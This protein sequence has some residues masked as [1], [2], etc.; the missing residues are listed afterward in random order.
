MQIKRLFK[1]ISFFCLI[2]PL[3]CSKKDDLKEKVEIVKIYVSA[4]MSSCLLEDTSVEVECLLIKEDNQEYYRKIEIG[5]IEGFEYEKNYEYE[6][7]V[8]KTTIAILQN[9]TKKY[10]YKLVEIISK[11]KVQFKYVIQTEQKNP[12][13]L[14]PEGGVFEIPFY[15]YRAK[16]VENRLVQKEYYSLKSLKYR[17]CTN[18]G[19]LTS[20][21]K[22]GE[23]VGFYKFVIERRGYF[24]M[25]GNPEWYCSFY[26][27]DVDLLFDVISVPIYKQIFEQSQ[28]EG[29]EYNILPIIN[30]NSGIFEL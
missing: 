16:Y 28:T 10:K 18:F 3:S 1:F 8:E 29:E 30:I 5:S 6:L 20:I 27:S 21:E 2:F 19:G 22:N 9:N 23:F 13:I 24:N 15:V 7:F 14:P 12:F 26:N 17:I 11:D 25:R 4:E